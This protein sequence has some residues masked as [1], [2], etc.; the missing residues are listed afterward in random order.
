VPGRRPPADDPTDLD[1]HTTV[2]GD[3]LDR[4][5]PGRKIR[6]KHGSLRAARGDRDDGRRNPSPSHTAPDGAG[7][8]PGRRRGWSRAASESHWARSLSLEA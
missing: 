6:D 2:T 8:R 5:G 7:R 1:G 4:C 3:R